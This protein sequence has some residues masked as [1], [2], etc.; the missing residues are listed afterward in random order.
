MI[1][2]E[3]THPSR[4]GELLAFWNAAFAG[5]RN[6]RPLAEQEWQQRVVAAPA[7]DA[8]GLILAVA[9][10]GQIVGGIHAF[11]PA[12]NQGVYQLYHQR[13][14][15]AWL[16]VAPAWRGQG[17]G[18]RLLHAAENFMYYCPVYFAAESTPLYGSVEGPRP[19]L[20]GSSQRMGLSLRSDRPL[21]DWLASRGYAVVE[22][23]DVSLARGLDAPLPRPAEPDWAALGLRPAV[24]SH[25]A[26]WTGPGYD[27]LRLWENDGRWPYAAT[28]L[29]DTAGAAAARVVW[30]PAPK[31]SGDAAIVRLD[32]SAAWQ[33]RGLGSYLLDR[34][35]AEM[36]AAGQARVEVQSHVTKHPRAYQ[37]YIGRGFLLEDAWASLVKT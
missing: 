8:R 29:V 31:D 9:E 17:I 30:R 28:V 2:L 3:T 1:R 25:L 21:I 16:M 18:R 5:R 12:P 26:P 23:G 27:E 11:R 15:I 34:A 24:V 20:F 4:T 6:F 19:P 32:V 14:H 37:L 10:D 22:P 36:A 35:L 7:F 33:G 13:H